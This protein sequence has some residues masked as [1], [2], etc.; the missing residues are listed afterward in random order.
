MKKIILLFILS[1][2]MSSYAQL[3]KSELVK[4]GIISGKVIDQE[5]KESLPYVNIVIRDMAKK[6]ITGGIT[7]L[8][9]NFRIK[10]IPEGNSIV[11]VQFIGYKTYSK[12]ISVSAKNRKLNLGTVLLTEDTTTLDEVVIR[13][14]ISTVVQK[15][16]RK[17]INVGKG[18]TAAGST[19]AELLN[20]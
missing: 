18:L 3:T 11:E 15:I 2:T 1:L 10:D 17:V 9:G 8:D 14:E 13:A 5:T 12:Q 7:D 16:D 6:I 20:I 4:P 19:A